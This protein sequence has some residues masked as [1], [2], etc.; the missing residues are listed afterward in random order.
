MGLGLVA[1]CGVFTPLE[2][3]EDV[4][5]ERY[6][7]KWYEVARYP[8]SFQSDACQYTTAEY[9]VLDDGTVTVDNRLRGS[10]DG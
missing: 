4:D 1:G 8:N 10:G 3:A 2:V 9:A 5:I 7:G 6:A